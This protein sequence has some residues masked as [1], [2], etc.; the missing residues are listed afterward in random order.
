MSTAAA[1]L[2]FASVNAFLQSIMPT[3]VISRSLATSA[4]SNLSHNKFS[5]WLNVEN[6][7]KSFRSRR[8]S[9]RYLR[10][11]LGYNRGNSVGAVSAV[12]ASA[13]AVSSTVWRGRL[14]SNS[15]CA[16]VT[17]WPTVARIT[18]MER[19]ASVVR[20]NGESHQIGVAIGVHERNDGNLELA[21]LGQ[22][23]CSRRMSTTNSAAGILSIARM[24]SKYLCNRPA[25]RRM[26][27]CS[28]FP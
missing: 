7:R 2:P 16:S 15:A 17:A 3:P 11:G 6:E 8:K 14:D 18:R 19:M 27:D 25:S 9:S 28:C 12:C 1:R 26:E 4:A 21:R 13:G 23:L 22:A 24:P 5:L 10:S 20:G